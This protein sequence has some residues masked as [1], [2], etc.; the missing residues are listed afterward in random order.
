VNFFSLAIF[1]VQEEINF[2]IF[3]MKALVIYY[4]KK[5]TTRQ[6]AYEIDKYLKSVEFES[7]MISIYDVQ[8][9]DIN[10]A[11]IVLIGC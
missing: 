8:P 9:E 4:S 6:F 3:K 1:T 7:K 11:D 5:G 2:L 10:Q